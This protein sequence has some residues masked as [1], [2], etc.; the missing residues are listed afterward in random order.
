MEDPNS[1]GALMSSVNVKYE[2]P[3]AGPY[4][5]GVLDGVTLFEKYQ[6]DNRA[7]LLWASMLVDLQ[8]GEPYSISQGYLCVSRVSS[9]PQQQ[10]VVRSSSRLSGKLFGVSAHVDV[11]VARKN[12][13]ASKARLDRAQLRLME[14]AEL[15]NGQ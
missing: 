1:A 7:I 8:H 14:C 15:Q 11:P 10:S 2:D 3:V 5:S 4:V 12:Q 6:E 13:I 9:N